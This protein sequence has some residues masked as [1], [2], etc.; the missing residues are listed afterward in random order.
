MLFFLFS[1][2]FVLALSRLFP[3]FIYKATRLFFEES[4]RE[5]ERLVD[6]LRKGYYVF[7]AI[8]YCGFR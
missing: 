2:D 6:G 8:I 1:R 3:R 4:E 7:F 5:Q